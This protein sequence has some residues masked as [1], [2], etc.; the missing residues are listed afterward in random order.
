MKD[1]RTRED[2]KTLVNAFYRKVRSDAVL[3]PVFEDTMQVDWETHLPKMY[4]FWETALFHRPRY[5]GNPVTVH[6]Q[7]HAQSP[8]EKIQFDTWIRLFNE[9]VDEHF[10]GEIAHQAKVRALSIATVLQIKTSSPR[11]SDEDLPITASH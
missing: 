1:I 3:S 10:T 9:T 6:Q 2:I 5:K 11:D 7:V 8:L 4:D